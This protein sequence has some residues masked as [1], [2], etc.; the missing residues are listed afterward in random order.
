MGAAIAGAGAHTAERAEIKLKNKPLT[1]HTTA[2][3]RRGTRRHNQAGSGPSRRRVC[4]SS[5]LPRDN[6]SR[7]RFT[8]PSMA[9]DGGPAGG[10]VG[11][12]HGGDADKTAALEDRVQK[13]EAQLEMTQRHAAELARLVAGTRVADSGDNDTTA[14]VSLVSTRRK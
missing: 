13:L 6:E 4:H 11:V 2:Q 3:L 10:G 8:P 1:R 9:S 5:A 12:G 14:A 7:A